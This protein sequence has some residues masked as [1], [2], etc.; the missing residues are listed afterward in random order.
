LRTEDVIATSAVVIGRAFR[1]E[2]QVLA[3]TD[4]ARLEI[5][6]PVAQLPEFEPAIAQWTFDKQQPAGLGTDTLPGSSWLYLPL[7]APSRTR[8][9]LALKPKLRRLLLVPEQLRQLETFAALV[10]IAL[11]RVHYVDVAQNA[12]VGM[13]SERLRN[14]LLSALSHDL[15]TPLAAVV[16]LAES[17]TLTKPDLSTQQEE[18]ARAIGEEARRMNALVNNLLDMARIESGQ[19]NLNLQWQPIEEVIGSALSSLH[20]LLAEHRVKIELAPGLPLVQFDAILIERVLANL[21]ENAAKYTPPGTLV[22]ITAEAVQSNLIVT[23]EDNGPGLPQGREEALFEKFAR[24]DME[25]ATSGVGLGLAICRA[26]VR[27]HGGE[28]HAEPAQGRGARFV[29]RLPLGQPPQLV[30]ELSESGAH[31]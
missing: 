17:L 22:R 9:V 11:E 31:V 23:V 21:L 1:G 14:S 19:I 6:K 3:G 12:L 4:G 5:P 15:R 30:D 2:V 24:G 7:R 10:A 18:L 8:G 25:S 26:I 28:I 27:A 16:G 13:E 29:F 20:A